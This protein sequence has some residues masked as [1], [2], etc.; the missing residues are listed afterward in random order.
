MEDDDKVDSANIMEREMNIFNISWNSLNNN[1]KVLEQY[2][3]FIQNY[4]DIMNQYYM[5]L[6]ELNSKF[7]NFSQ[8]FSENEFD[9]I[10]KN[11]SQIFSASIQIQLN[12]LLI[13]LSKSQSLVHSL[14]QSITQSKNLIENF[15]KLNETIYYNIKTL[16]N[17]YH[18]D[19]LLLINS[20]QN[21]EN[22]LVEN[23]VK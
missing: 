3:S 5:S 20:F 19:Y 10:I 22:K 16:N 12:N 11:I 9:T 15:K 18:K 1:C 8:E 7:P 4:L 21:L 2:S 6:T 17:N 23:Y 13:F 14:N